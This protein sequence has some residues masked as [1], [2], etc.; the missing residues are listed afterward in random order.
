MAEHCI[1]VQQKLV[2]F[3]NSVLHQSVQSEFVSDIQTGHPGHQH[4]SYTAANPMKPRVLLSTL[5]AHQLLASGSV[6]TVHLHQVVY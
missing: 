3:T 2:A 1:L 5:S 4:C 6:S